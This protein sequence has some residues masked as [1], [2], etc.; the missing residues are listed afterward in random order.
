M[1]VDIFSSFD[2]ATTSLFQISPL[3]FW[4]F[5]II[6]L[7]IIH[8]L[9]W[10]SKSQAFWLI[11]I[12]LRIIRDQSR[13]TST[14]HLKSLTTLIVALYILITSINFLG[15]IPFVFS[16][17][18]HLLFTLRF[19]LPLWF[20][21]IFSSVTFSP[22][23]TLASLLPAGAPAW[24][25]PFLIL[26][27]TVSIAVRPITLSFRLAA[28]IRAGHIVLTLMGVYLIFALLS[29]STLTFLSLF[30]IQAGYTLFEVGICLIQAYI[31]CLLLT[32]YTDDHADNHSH[33]LPFLTK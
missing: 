5:N 13:R 32:L 3:L 27:E 21:L 1:I 19:G 31:F 2:P 7:S 14:T 12:P 18:S 23:T 9:F 29:N 10:A 20:A 15:I 11:S 26:I 16:A 30:I 22:F 33:S 6:I 28:N 25:N 24:L 17:T 8:P 4:S